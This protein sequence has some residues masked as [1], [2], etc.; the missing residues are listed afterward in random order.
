MLYIYFCNLQHPY[1]RCF[2][3]LGA[4]EGWGPGRGG[5][6]DCYFTSQFKTCTQKQPSSKDS[7]IHCYSICFSSTKHVVKIRES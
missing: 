5:G 2:F 6:G 4:V 7:C 3:R 1:K